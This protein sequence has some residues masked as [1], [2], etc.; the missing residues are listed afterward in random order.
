MKRSDISRYSAVQS[1]GRWRLANV[2][3]RAVTRINK[4]PMARDTGLKYTLVADMLPGG[5]WTENWGD[6]DGR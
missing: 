1:R 5:L 6:R 2:A 3:H 4:Q